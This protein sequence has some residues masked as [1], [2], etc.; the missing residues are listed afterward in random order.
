MKLRGRHWVWSRLLALQQ[1][2]RSPVADEDDGGN[3]DGEDNA[4]GDGGDDQEE[5]HASSIAP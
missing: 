2:Q 4:R 1:L 3:E 5:R